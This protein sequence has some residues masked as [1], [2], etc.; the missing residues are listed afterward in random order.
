MNRLPHGKIYGPVFCLALCCVIG[1]NRGAT[2]E[3]PKSDLKNNVEKPLGI[4][5]P[6]ELKVLGRV[7][8][9]SLT[10]QA[11]NEVSSDQME[12]K[13]WVATFIFTRCGATCPA[14]T[15]AFAKL[16]KSLRKSGAWGTVELVTITVDPEF[17]TPAVMKKYGEKAKADFEHWRFLTGDR[18]VI[19]DLSKDGFKL[20]ILSPRDGNELI[21]HSPM[22]V[23]VDNQNQIR[24]YY[25]GISP[26]AN[27]K[28]KMD[29]LWL[30]DEQVPEWK[31]RVLEIAVPSDVRSPSW[32]PE[33]AAAQRESIA[34][35]K[36]RHDFRF[37]DAREESGIS[38]IDKV[39]E[40]VKRT[41]KAAHYDHGS[42][43][44]VADV[45]ND[46]L[47]DL[48][49]VCQLG[50]N[51]LWRNLGNGKFENITA[52]SG[53]AVPEEVSVG[54]SFADIDNDG[55]VDLYVT[56][57]RAPNKLFRGDGKGHFIDISESAGV[58][59]VGHSSGSV[60]F[61]YDRDG[62]LDLLL[63][64]VGR[65]TTE[66]RGEGFYTAYAGAF[67]GHLHSDR[68]EPNILYHNLGDGRFENVNARLGFEDSSWTGDATPIDANDDGWPDI[69][70]LNMQG[71][72]EYYENQSGER[73]VKKS[74]ELFP[75]TAWGTMGVKV[76]DYDRDGRLDL[77]VTDMHTDMV[78]DLA[79]DKEKTKMQRN[80]PLKVLATDGN[81]QL[82]NTFFRKTGKNQFEEISDRIHAENYWPWG[83]SV[84]DLNADGFEDVFVAASMNY[85][86]R[87]GINS[88]LLN[89]AG[90]KFV[91]SE[92]VL[93]VEPRS[94]G[95]AQ[96]WMELDCS[97]AHRNNRHC[98]DCG[99]KVLIW[100]ATGTRSSVIFD[101][102]G[103]GDL[104][105]V[106]NDFGGTPMVLR[107]D[108]S[109]KGSLHY[110]KVALIGSE[111]NRDG[112]G[113]IVR[114]HIGDQEMLSAHDGKSGYLAQ[115]SLPLYFGLGEAQS[116]DRI[117][118]DWPSGKHQIVTG[119][120]ASNQQLTIQEQS[121][122]EESQIEAKSN[123]ASEAND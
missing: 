52:T 44:A 123:D 61:D 77:Y 66:H 105:I 117:E 18:G 30:L 16:Q 49:F 12:G 92:F 119:P 65:Y 108:L 118:V 23:L 46:G 113:A 116:V 35:E 40:D 84:G 95:T 43:V 122:H 83:I 89:D 1:C 38:F 22:F 75:K 71:H 72:D 112:I 80:L 36:V 109:E 2:D 48:Y 100:A 32:I 58:D 96:A 9:F 57:V 3:S 88:V 110:L 76:F 31:D 63:T 4:E 85:P 101:V 59:H 19:W 54:A 5:E 20:P 120:I 86:Y 8:A 115:S 24:G 99:G 90:K 39:V 13:I 78:H 91:D 68:A 17:D 74:R 28:L 45:D 114:V 98:E 56:R 94:K 34:V 93:G 37:E 55:N 81:H 60:F 111:S 21:S 41:F 102:E 10:D 104:D 97:G 33:R 25:S 6:V 50:E 53:V 14:Q 51:E 73:F 47:S 79:P 7:P 64:N 103:D 87:Y 106:T 26:Q 70:L 27:E 62:L 121:S 82:G 15:E 67:T 107:S 42:A 11:G 69:Y 29:I